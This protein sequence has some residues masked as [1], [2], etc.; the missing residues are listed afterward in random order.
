MIMAKK[1]LL[2]RLTR[3]G[4]DGKLET[5][6]PNGEAVDLTKDDLATLDRL[7]KATGKRYY[8]DPVNESAAE[9]ERADDE[10][11]DEPT[12]AETFVNRAVGDISED[13]I[14]ALSD[15]QRAAALAAEEA[16]KGRSTLIA[17]LQPAAGDKDDGL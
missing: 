11:G 9:D 13:E 5:L 1:V 8:R 7:T 16:G 10:E 4:K 2:G 15:E 12:E 17:R 14:A 6:M 3:P